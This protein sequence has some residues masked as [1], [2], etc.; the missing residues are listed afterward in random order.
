M[1][2]GPRSGSELRCPDHRTLMEPVV[3]QLRP[4]SPR[5]ADPHK[6]R[7]AY[8]QYVIKRPFLSLLG[9]KDY[10]YAPDG[11]QVMFL[12]HP[13]LK[14]RG[15]FTIYTDETERRRCFVRARKWSPSTWPRRHRSQHRGKDRQH[16]LAPPEVHLPRYL[17]SARCRRPGHRS[18]RGDRPRAASPTSS[19]PARPGTR[20]SSTA[21][22]S[23]PSSRPSVSSSRRRCSIFRPAAT[24]STTEFGWPRRCS[25]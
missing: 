10:V 25:P 7:F 22:S 24:G 3:A 4:S 15:E 20:S 23:R 8:Q 21:S 9:R 12:K 19:G 17:G 14:R 18:D 6:D 13:L 5:S 2:T 16:P 11:S 1:L